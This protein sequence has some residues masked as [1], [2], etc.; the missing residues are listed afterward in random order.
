MS[1]VLMQ[2]NRGRSDLE[3]KEGYKNKIAEH[4]R[5]KDL[6]KI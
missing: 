4:K 6:D 5:L 1:A 3:A 2:K